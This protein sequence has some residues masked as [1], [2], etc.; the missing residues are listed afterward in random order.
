MSG[1]QDERREIRCCECGFLVGFSA[2]PTDQTIAIE[3]IYCASERDFFANEF[4]PV[5][6]YTPMY[7]YETIPTD[8]SAWRRG[9]MHDRKNSIRWAREEIEDELSRTTSSGG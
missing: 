9:L 3:C 5:S 4:G 6:V 1:G 8:K 7:I 2:A